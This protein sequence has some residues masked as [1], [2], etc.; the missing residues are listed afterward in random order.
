MMTSIACETVL[1]HAARLLTWA[2]MH[3]VARSAG[4]EGAPKVGHFTLA[5]Q[6]VFMRWLRDKHGHSCK[7]IATYLTYIKAAMRFAA[8]PRVI[9]DAKGIEREVLLLGSAPYIEDGEKAISKVTQLPPSKPRDFIPTDAQLA[10]M[11][12]ALPETEEHEAAFRYTIMALNTWARPEA[13][14]EL[15]VTTQI[16]FTLGLIH[17][18][19]P[20]RIQNKKLRPTIRLTDNLRAW[21][22]YWNLD[23]PIVG[24]RLGLPV[25]AISARTP[26]KA[27]E[28]AAI[29]PARVN[30]YM[31]RHFMA[32]RAKRVPGVPVSREERAVWLGHL[33]PAHK[34]TQGWYV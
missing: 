21:L 15:S 29:D 27:A 18:N 2:F 30:R 23:R 8:K 1:T 19:P 12:D 20:G 32:T 14:T 31:L 28:R 24:K 10:A 7:T 4:I 6:Q 25:K 34:T 13:I 22:L 3:S 11:L 16:D 33:D 5:R 26:K 17:L 9:K